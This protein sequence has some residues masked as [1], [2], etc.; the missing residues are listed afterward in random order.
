MSDYFDSLE[1]ELRAAVPRVAGPQAGHRPWPLRALVPALAVGVALAVG[2]AV[3][4]LGHA[5]RPAP[6]AP[7][8]A[9]EPAQQQPGR[10]APTPT[11][12]QLVAN[13][14][15]L[16]RSQTPADRSWPQVRQAF[17]DVLSRYTRLATRVGSVTR[18]FLT[19][20]HPHERGR[21]AAS[22]VLMTISIVDRNGNS[23]STDF[24][25]NVN[26]NVF[27]IPNGGPRRRVSHSPVVWAGI[28]PDGV[29]RVAW[30]FG[31]PPSRGPAGRVCAARQSHTV[32]VNVHGNVAAAGVLGNLWGCPG[33]LEPTSVTW[34]GPGGGR[35]GT[36]NLRTFN[37]VAP[38]FVIGGRLLIRSS[39]AGAG[40]P[41]HHLLG[42]DGIGALRFG[43]SRTRTQRVLTAL[44]GVRAL[45]RTTVAQCGVDGLADWRARDGGLLS[46]YFDRGRFVGYQF[47]NEGLTRP[48]E[49]LQAGLRLA[50]QGEGG[51]TLGETLAQA[52]EHYGSRFVISA[53][54]G[55]SWEVSTS[56]G[57]IDG[58]TFVRSGK[59]VLSPSNLVATIDA[60]TVGCPAVSP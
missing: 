36:F 38:P 39:R 41:V 56:S 27:P 40:P 49:P 32:R 35:L 46:V 21:A 59:P 33:C 54:Q 20:S 52:R 24:G 4:L 45:P 3:L 14:G 55:G 43:A 60:G 15:V 17:G 51:L 50:T 48:V 7:A 6:T 22:S 37:L 44:T 2:A 42:G 57:R 29:S 5:R 34:Y 11:L 16:R 8:P 1:A 19:V 23:A 30:T 53:A 10:L 58:Y 18:V 28:V 25:P 12:A 9:T 31:C 47:G 13:F 26:Y